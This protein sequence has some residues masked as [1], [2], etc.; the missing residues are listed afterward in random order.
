MSGVFGRDYEDEKPTERR[1]R[2]PKRKPPVASTLRRDK[3][4]LESDRG[5]KLKK[6]GVAWTPEEDDQ[7]LELVFAQHKSET[8]VADAM[9]RGL[10]G[11]RLRTE[12]LVTRDY[13]AENYEPRN[14]TQRTEITPLDAEWIRKALCGAGRHDVKE[15][16][17]KPDVAWVSKV[18]GLP[19]QAV[20]EFYREITGA[21]RKG[22]RL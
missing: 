1:R 4:R 18:L 22:F 20:A 19:E 8:E 14:R 16:N 17:V 11:V 5:R 12:R 10:R 3:H 6:D 21:N 13:R 7:L 15:R 9:D 2:K